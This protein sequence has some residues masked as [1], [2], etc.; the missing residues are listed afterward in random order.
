MQFRHIS[1]FCAAAHE[2]GGFQ[3]ESEIE[4]NGEGENWSKGCG[5]GWCETNL[6][7]SCVSALS[8]KTCCRTY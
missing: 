8:L 6:R 5:G 3:I 1:E 4:R 7:D 2:R